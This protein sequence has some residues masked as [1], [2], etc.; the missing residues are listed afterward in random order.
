MSN[1]ISESD[2]YW[3]IS[4]KHQNSFEFY[5]RGFGMTKITEAK[6]YVFILY[7]AVQLGYNNYFTRGQNGVYHKWNVNTNSL[8][9]FKVVIGQIAVRETFWMANLTEN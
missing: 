4:F 6:L 5:L 8:V 7:L 2:K 9:S 3:E 1:K